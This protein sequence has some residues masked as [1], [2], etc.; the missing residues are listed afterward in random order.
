[1]DFLD[2]S[3]AEAAKKAWEWYCVESEHIDEAT[4]CFSGEHFVV[5]LVDVIFQAARC[6]PEHLGNLD[7]LERCGRSFR[8]ISN[9]VDA[10]C[11][12]SNED[13]KEPAAKR[14]SLAIA[15]LNLGTVVDRAFVR[16]IAVEPTVP[17]CVKVEAEYAMKSFK[18]RIAELLYSFC[19]TL[20]RGPENA[21]LGIAGFVDAVLD[22]LKSDAEMLAH[23]KTHRAR[24]I[25]AIEP[26]PRVKNPSCCSNVPYAS[27]SREELDAWI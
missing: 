13:D 22:D 5:W 12:A 27:F 8:N 16:A 17:F 18:S 14:A 24:V 15:D 26:N 10:L 2:L 23:A 20:D 7:T 9:L 21:C 19:R 11:D 1:M 4:F 3:V 25:L 6:L